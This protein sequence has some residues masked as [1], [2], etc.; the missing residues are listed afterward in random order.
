M[1]LRGSLTRITQHTSRVVSIEHDLAQ[2]GNRSL[3]RLTHLI[4]RARGEQRLQVIEQNLH[5]PRNIERRAI[6]DETPRHHGRYRTGQLIRIHGSRRARFHRAGLHEPERR[7]VPRDQL[8]DQFDEHGSVQLIEILA[9]RIAFDLADNGTRIGVENRKADGHQM[10]TEVALEIV[11]TRALAVE[12][13]PRP[14]ESDRV[15]PLGLDR[16]RGLPSLHLQAADVA[17]VP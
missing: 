8:G 4:S 1:Q 5:V 11:R 14:G 2:P 16:R 6:I 15:D 12:R 13:T 10:F 17:H 7:L 3:Q 9:Q